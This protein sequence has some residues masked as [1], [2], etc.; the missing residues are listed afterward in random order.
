MVL[1]SYFPPCIEMWSFGVKVLR[2]TEKQTR[3]KEERDL[4]P[5]V[6]QEMSRK[7]FSCAAWQ[8][9]QEIW[10]VFSFRGSWLFILW[11][12]TD[13]WKSSPRSVC[14]L[15]RQCT[16]GV[17]VVAA[18]CQQICRNERGDGELKHRHVQVSSRRVI[19][20]LPVECPNHNQLY[21]F[22][23][24]KVSNDIFAET[25]CSGWV[26]ALLERVVLSPHSLLTASCIQP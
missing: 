9:E 21:F 15:C 8:L 17:C 7:T 23:S 22:C 24:V 5:L 25:K 10:A 20:C 18:C 19:S 11:T 4:W 1:L 3:K 6:N 16:V 14:S 12:Q 2:E 26:S 13:R